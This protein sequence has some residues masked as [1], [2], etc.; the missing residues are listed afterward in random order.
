MSNV[1]RH[2]WAAALLI[3]VAA[4]AVRDVVSLGRATIQAPFTKYLAHG[5]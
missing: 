3:L 2:I 4:A 5:R 1:A